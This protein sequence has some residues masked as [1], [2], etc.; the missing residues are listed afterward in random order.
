LKNLSKKFTI[1]QLDSW[2]VLRTW[3]CCTENVNL[4]SCNFSYSNHSC[5]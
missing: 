1:K 2:S 5:V 4:H 3:S